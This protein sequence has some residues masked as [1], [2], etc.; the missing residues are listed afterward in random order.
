MKGA[1]YE[2]HRRALQ[3][4]TAC[5]VLVGAKADAT[6]RAVDA[7]EPYDTGE[8]AMKWLRKKSTEVQ[9]MSAAVVVDGNYAAALQNIAAKLA[10]ADPRE[11]ARTY[12][13]EALAF[14]KSKQATQENLT[15]I[16]WRVAGGA[17]FVAL[18]S[19][20][21]SAALVQLKRPTPPVIIKDNTAT[22]DVQV[23]DVARSGSVTFGELEV[24][25]ALRDYVK[26]REGY[27][28]YTIQDAYDTV[29]LMNSPRE[30]TLYSA[31]Y[32]RKNSPL[33]V[34]TDKFRVIAQP[35]AI[36]FVGTTAQVFFSKKTISLSTQGG[37]TPMPPK[38]EY[39]VATI[40]YEVGDL[41]T[42]SNE[43]VLNPIGFRVTSYSVDRDW[44]RSATDGVAM[45]PS[46]AT[47]SESAPSSTQGGTAR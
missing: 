11:M 22:G 38:T 39:W 42:K 2:I 37:S 17:M 46:A 40:T 25:K 35:G 8:R 13:K 34:L 7:R 6:E 20:L 27:D 43:Q 16:A 3:R 24:R 12:F 33:N 36:T 29:T 19:I 15:K 18:V 47:S 28:W 4:R 26:L 32:N 41:P 10:E 45:I 5:G 1:E 9:G 23:I 14:E 30:Q 44:T 21:G 31:L